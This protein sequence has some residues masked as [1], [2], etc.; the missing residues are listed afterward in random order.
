M[1]RLPLLLGLFFV[2]GA[3]GLLYQV[4]WTRLFVHVFGATVLAVA[5]V[6]AAFMGGLAAGGVWGGRA[7]AR[8]GNPLRWYGILEIGIG[9]Y[10]LFVSALVA[11]L[12]PLYIRLYPALEGSFARLSLARF[13]TSALVLFPPTFLMG[14]TLPLITEHLERTGGAIARDRVARLYGVNTFGAVAGTVVASFILVPSVGLSRTLVLGVAMSLAVGLVSLLLARGAPRPDESSEPVRTAT[15]SPTNPSPIPR[16]ALLFTTAALGFSALAFEV[17][18][19]RTLTLSLGTTTYAFAVV[20][21]VFLV[22][23]AI[24]GLLAERFLAT[25]RA[26]VLFL[27]APAAIGFLSLLVLPVFDRLPQAFVAIS[28]R[29]R[30]DWTQVLLAQIVV[31]GL[32]LLLPT[33]LSGAA[34]PLAIA[35]DRATPRAGRSVGDVY[36][37]NTLGAILGSWGAGFVLIPQLGLRNGIALAAALP[38]AATCVLLV[39]HRPARRRAWALAAILAASAVVLF[40]ALPDWNRAALTRGGFAIGAELRRR[41]RTQLGEDTSELLFVEEGITTTVTVRRWRDD[42]TM[43]MNGITEASNVGDLAT[44]VMAGGLA[45]LLHERPRDVLVIG[46]GSGI[47]ASAVARHPSVRTIECVEIAESVIHAARFFEESNRGVMRDPRFRMIQGDGRNHLRL[48]RGTYD[49]IVSQPSNVWNAGTSAL[50]TQEFFAL[51]RDHLRP[52]GILCSWIQGYSLSSDALRSV[53]A[54]ARREF[55]RVSLWSAAYGD[56]LVVAGDDAFVIDVERILARAQEPAIAEMLV[57][58]DSPDLVTL[59]SNLHLAGEPLDRWLGEFPPNTDDNLYLEFEAPRLLHHQTMPELFT[60]VLR[61]A[62]GTE[63]LLRSAPP[64]LAAQLASARTARELESRARLSFRAEQGAEGLAAA[65]E[66]HRLHPTSPPIRGLLAQALSARGL[67]LANSGDIGGAAQHFLRAADLDAR[68]GEPLANLARL[69]RDGGQLEAA[70]AAIDE[71]LRRQPR[72]PEFLA[73]SADLSNR[74]R[75]F[76]EARAAAELALA[77]DG[78]LLDG[79]LALS[80][81]LASL[82]ESAVADSVLARGAAFHPESEEIARRLRKLRAGQAPARG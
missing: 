58:G 57:Q 3:A 31:A 61:A 1:T 11:F 19:T 20:L 50:M 74:A 51:C 46:L 39:T 60:S 43:Q 42:I 45:P 75:R 77:I 33:I 41:G 70:R 54:A 59:L 15:T 17:L 40:A 44:Q 62:G 13:A 64:G 9:V 81:A 76:A 29:G 21:A 16:P 25:R 82:G 71:A 23:I 26:V 22:G 2:S 78:T 53:V 65:E 36:G 5:T 56:L 28:N 63:E 67:A 12:D 47:T 34:F 6:L 30:G 8:L 73:F 24:G 66:A 32:P 52:G 72:D 10:A 7:A 35:L 48:A 37:A 68:L 27:A 4:V 38:I 79:Y 49:C 80:D 14:A 69:Y 18:W 55:P